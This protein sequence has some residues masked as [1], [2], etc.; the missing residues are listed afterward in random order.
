MSGIRE[1]R[2]QEPLFQALLNAVKMTGEDYANSYRL[3]MSKAV[4]ELAAL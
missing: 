1:C 2:S 4:S 3:R